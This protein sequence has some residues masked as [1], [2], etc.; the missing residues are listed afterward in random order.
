M[1]AEQLRE[2]GKA[3]SRLEA[4]RLAGVEKAKLVLRRDGAAEETARL[5]IVRIRAA[6]LLADAVDER[7]A[8]TAVASS[9]LRT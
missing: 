2:S 6:K 5:A 8:A 1:Q 3:S 4:F 7:R 9:T